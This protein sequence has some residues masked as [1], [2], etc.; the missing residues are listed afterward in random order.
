MKLASRHIKYG[1]TPQRVKEVYKTLGCNLACARKNTGMSQTDVM[2]AIWGRTNSRNRISEIENGKAPISLIDLLIFQDLYG[3]S[4]DYICGLSVEP[5]IDMIASTTNHIIHQSKSLGESIIETVSEVL[6][7]T[8]K[9]VHKSDYVALSSNIKALIKELKKVD[10][11]PANIIDILAEII[12]VIRIIDVKQAKNAM[13]IEAQKD[14]IKGRIDKQE[15]HK[16]LTDIK[17]TCQLSLPLP[18]PSELQG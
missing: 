12:S 14:F 3:Q 13:A 16:L 1:Y 2:Q 10:G 6:V 15:N 11:L 7:E 8:L 17:Q 4:L 5:E 18:K 9:D